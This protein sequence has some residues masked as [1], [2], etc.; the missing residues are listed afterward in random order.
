MLR[1]SATGF[2][3]PS[4]SRLPTHMLVLPN[5]GKSGGVGGGFGGAILSGHPIAGPQKKQGVVSHVYWL[6]H[7]AQAAM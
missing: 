1:V 6:H 3:M 2:S 4:T 7:S 5:V